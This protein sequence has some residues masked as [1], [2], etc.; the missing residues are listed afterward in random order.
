MH[1]AQQIKLAT[2]G[3]FGVWR[4][5]VEMAG[6]RA[7][8]AIDAGFEV[9]RQATVGLGAHDSL[10]ARHPFFVSQLLRLRHFGQMVNGFQETVKNIHLDHERTPR[11]P[12]KVAS[13]MRAGSTRNACMSLPNGNH[14][15]SSS[16]DSRCTASVR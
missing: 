5:L 8:A 3:V 14:T 11:R 4:T 13:C 15:S 6:L 7:I 12:K 16:S 10:G 2:G 9:Q 1:A